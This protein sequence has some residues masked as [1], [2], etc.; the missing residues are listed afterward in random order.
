MPDIPRN[1]EPKGRWGQFS[2]TASF[3]VLMFL[4]P[5]LIYQ[6]ARPNSRRRAEE[7]SYTMYLTQLREK[8]IESVTVI[9]GKKVEGKLRTPIAVQNKN[10]V[11]EFWTLL[12]IKDSELE[13][14][15][16]KVNNVPI[17]AVPL[18]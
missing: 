17:K 5:L 3:W 18:R 4:I 8:N 7:L 1:R 14:A 16:L 13:L 9:D 6:V 12:P 2:R 10:R 15:E 11:S